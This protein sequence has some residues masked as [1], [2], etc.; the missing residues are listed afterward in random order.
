MLGCS[1]YMLRM[2]ISCSESAVQEAIHAQ[3]A[4]IMP[5]NKPQRAYFIDFTLLLTCDVWL[6]P[7]KSSIIIRQYRTC[8][9]NFRLNYERLYLT[10]LY[11]WY[12]IFLSSTCSNSGV[13]FRWICCKANRLFSLQLESSP[14]FHVILRARVQIWWGSCYHNV[15]ILHM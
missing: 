5:L 9:F 11:I 6:L 3:N 8:S 15:L 1:E 10:I 12:L 2:L 4:Y 7:S 14:S 13:W